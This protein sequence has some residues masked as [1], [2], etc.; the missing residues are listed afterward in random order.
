MTDYGFPGGYEELVTELAGR[1]FD[2]LAEKCVN[3]PLVVRSR[4]IVIHHID[5]EL[6]SE[7]RRFGPRTGWLLDAADLIDGG[8]S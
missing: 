1:L 2:K 3:G 8:E 5:T 4:G 6:A 7:L